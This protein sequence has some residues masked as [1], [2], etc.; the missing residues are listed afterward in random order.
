MDDNAETDFEQSIAEIYLRFTPENVD[1]NV[2]VILDDQETDDTKHSQFEP[3]I[4]IVNNYVAKKLMRKH[5]S[6]PFDLLKYKIAPCLTPYERCLHSRLSKTYHKAFKMEHKDFRFYVAYFNQLIFYTCTIDEGV[7]QINWPHL[8]S[9][10]KNTDTLQT[11]IVA[12]Y[13]IPSKYF[14]VLFF[15]IHYQ[16]FNLISNSANNFNSTDDDNDIFTN[17]INQRMSNDVHKKYKIDTQKTLTKQDCFLRKDLINCTG[18]KFCNYNK[19][20][21]GSEHSFFISH[22]IKNTLIFCYN[23]NIIPVTTHYWQSIDM[24]HCNM[25]DEDLMIFLRSIELNAKNGNHNYNDINNNNSNNINSRSCWA[26]LR[27]ID[28]SHNKNIT[29]KSMKYLFEKVIG[30]YLTNLE[31][32]RLVDCG[33]TVEMLIYINNCLKQVL[34]MLKQREQTDADYLKLRLESCFKLQMIILASDENLVSFPIHGKL[35]NEQLIVNT[36]KAIRKLALKNGYVRLDNPLSWWDASF[37]SSWLNI[38]VDPSWYS[39]DDDV[40]E[41][42]GLV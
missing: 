11:S 7:F 22:L 1:T 20:I 25:T 26:N 5:H 9:L 41:M 10:L 32:I 17:M 35:P 31:S 23:Y 21:T 28:L 2:A 30:H 27:K 33:I 19:D 24:Q 38:Q 40:A 16:I 4:I 13:K 18:L 12:K 6:I 39:F 36:K 29:N 3:I 42:Y 34:S 14:N 37:F 8:K 15:I